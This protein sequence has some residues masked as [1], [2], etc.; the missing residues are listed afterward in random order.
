MQGSETGLDSYFPRGST[1]TSTS[2]CAD[3]G[4]RLWGSASGVRDTGHTGSASAAAFCL[5]A[6]L[7]FA[8]VV[9]GGGAFVMGGAV[10]SAT[11]L[12]LAGPATPCATNPDCVLGERGLV[13]TRRSVAASLVAAFQLRPSLSP[14]PYAR[15]L[16]GGGQG[17]VQTRA[18]RSC[19]ASGTGTT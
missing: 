13:S 15:R 11:P 8:G 17:P 1:V 2:L 19:R 5:L 6:V 16:N 4:Q 10:I 14:V 3:G 12:S 7:V 18:A 9:I